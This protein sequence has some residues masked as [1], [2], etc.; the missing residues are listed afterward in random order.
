MKNLL[1]QKKRALQFG[2][3]PVTEVC[4]RQ[5]ESNKKNSH[6]KALKLLAKK[7]EIDKTTL[8]DD[9]FPLTVLKIFSLYYIIFYIKKI[10]NTLIQFI[11]ILKMIII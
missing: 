4:I 11:I 3:S 5:Y 7:L 6:A 10:I 9:C 2:L 8:L 1:S